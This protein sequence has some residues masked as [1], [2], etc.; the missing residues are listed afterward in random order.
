MKNPNRWGLKDTI[1]NVREWCWDWYA[2]NYPVGFATNYTGPMEGQVKILRG[3]TWQ[4]IAQNCSSTARASQPPYT[5]LYLNGFR[6]V[7]TCP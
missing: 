3:G 6:L 2:T 7:R 1:G 5:C 4:D